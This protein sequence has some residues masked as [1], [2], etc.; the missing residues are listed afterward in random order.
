MVV[1]REK[2]G[3]AEDADL[4]DTPDDV[5]IIDDTDFDDRDNSDFGG[6]DGGTRLRLNQAAARG[7]DP[8]PM[9]DRPGW[10]SAKK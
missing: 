4:S 7:T 9:L 5:N 8:P 6:D 10:S 2:R 1:S 3:A